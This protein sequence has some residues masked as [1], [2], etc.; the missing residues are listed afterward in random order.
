MSCEITNGRVEECKDS[1]SGLKSIYFANFDDLTTDNITY[2]AVGSDVIS[3]WEPA[4]ALS[5]YKY[6]LKSNS[7]SF[8]TTIETS[9]D[10]GTT[11]FT[12]TLVINLKKQ[13][14]DMHLNIKLL[15]Y[16]RPRII[17]R[18]M[19]DQFFMVGLAQGCDMGS[20]SIN[21]GAA[22]GD[23]NGYESLT[24]VSMEI[25][26]A[27]FINVTTQAGLALAF[28]DIAGTDAAIETT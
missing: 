20:G 18:T 13:D 5:L 1:V 28:A 25:S 7:N 14:F 24:F 26:P 10:N 8:T 6:E 27:N 17:V 22:L 23:F 2:T 19:T 11:F 21:S 15:A 12:Q 3:K 9:R 4:A 16:G